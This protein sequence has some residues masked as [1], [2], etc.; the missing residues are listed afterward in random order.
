MVMV[1]QTGKTLTSY[2]TQRYAQ[3]NPSYNHREKAINFLAV[4]SLVLN[5]RV[6]S[7]FTTGRNNN[8]NHVDRRHRILRK[9]RADWPHQL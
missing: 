2:K 4:P 1:V 3:K 9:E 5:G 6:H 7:F 8:C